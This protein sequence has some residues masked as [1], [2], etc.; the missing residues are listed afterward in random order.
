LK[1]D[2]FDQRKTLEAKAYEI[3]V[4]L[5]EVIEKVNHE[6]QIMLLAVTT[7]DGIVNGKILIKD[8]RK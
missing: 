3:F 8:D 4:A 1:A 6:R 2:L 7:L 5:A